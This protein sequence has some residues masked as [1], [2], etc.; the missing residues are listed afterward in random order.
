MY[1]RSK[2]HIAQKVE[3]CLA[4]PI[5]PLRN[6]KALKKTLLDPHLW[7]KSQKHCHQTGKI[8]LSVSTFVFGRIR[9]DHVTI[10]AAVL[11]NNKKKHLVRH[12][13]EWL[14]RLNKSTV[15]WSYSNRLVFPKRGKISQFGC[16][17]TFR[18]SIQ[19]L[20]TYDWAPLNNVHSGLVPF[21]DQ[22]SLAITFFFTP[23]FHS[24]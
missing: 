14:R 23:S 15:S 19:Q 2:T 13:L 7:L 4:Q 20:F 16:L 24:G 17:F 9:L 5:T 22:S 18:L 3:I 11:T 1:I 12:D 6:T 21:S 10:T 8:Y